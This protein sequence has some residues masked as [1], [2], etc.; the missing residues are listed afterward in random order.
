MISSQSAINQFVVNN[1]SQ[2]SRTIDLQSLLSSCSSLP[3]SLSSLA[4][5]A[6]SNGLQNRKLTSSTSMPSSN[7]LSSSLPTFSPNLPNVRPSL[8]QMSSCLPSMGPSLSQ[9]ALNLHNMGPGLSPMSS[10][11]PIMVPSL[12]QK[13]SN[14]PNMGTNFGSM[15]S[16]LPAV[17]P[18]LSP[19]L[20]GSPIMGPNLSQIASNLPAFTPNLP[21]AL[22][23]FPIAS[24]SGQT[25][26]IDMSVLNNLA[27]ALQ[28]LVLNNILS[29]SPEDSAQKSPCSN[30]N[31]VESFPN[32]IKPVSVS[33]MPVGNNED[34]YS[35]ILTQENEDL[36]NLQNANFL[37]SSG[38]VDNSMM[39]HNFGGNPV[40]Q[41]CAKYPLNPRTGYSLMSPYEALGPTSPFSDPIL[42]SPYAINSGRSN[43]N[44]PY[45]VYEPYSGFDS[46]LFS[47]TD[48]I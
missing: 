18:N 4:L 43:F 33:Y 47:L 24:P 17:R 1:P 11:S 31:L 12:S 30:T 21:P 29:T 39:L 23:N 22:S 38:F 6:I 9:M 8:A 36:N 48:I 40:T 16:N 32:A 27:V 14:F 10:G 34:Q 35:N 45:S 25:A 46:D 37:G 19:M 2:Q 7:M 26:E 20:S 44:S 15:A 28:L 41:S 42:S 13:T 5:T 3:P